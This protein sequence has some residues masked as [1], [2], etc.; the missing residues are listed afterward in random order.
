[1]ISKG[2]I[3]KRDRYSFAARSLRFRS[4][5][6]RAM[7]FLRSSLEAILRNACI[8][9]SPSA[10]TT[11]SRISTDTE[12]SDGGPGKL[13]M[14]EPSPSFLETMSYFQRVDQRVTMKADREKLNRLSRRIDEALQLARELDETMAACILSIAS[15]EVSERMELAEAQR[16]D[17]PG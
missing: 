1:M 3:S 9:S 13:T 14:F 2:M 11:L 16:P 6:A 10:V 4:R 5:S 8:N 15:R 7:T 17:E 12:I